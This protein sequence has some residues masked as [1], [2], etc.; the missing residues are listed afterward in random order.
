M[1]GFIGTEAVPGAKTAPGAGAVPRRRLAD[2]LLSLGEAP[3]IPL[4]ARF[5]TD[6][7]RIRDCP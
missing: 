3:T 1:Q 4:T 2:W 6:I 7:P 5:L